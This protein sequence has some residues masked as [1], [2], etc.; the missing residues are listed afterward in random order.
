MQVV[1]KVG[2]SS[3]GFS[4]V[5]HKCVGQWDGRGLL[6][7]CFDQIVLKNSQGCIVQMC[8]IIRRYEVLTDMSKQTATIC[9][10]NYDRVKSYNLELVL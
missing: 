9:N 6:C 1:E 3:V 2:N 10:R 4:G 7:D 5:D 8:P